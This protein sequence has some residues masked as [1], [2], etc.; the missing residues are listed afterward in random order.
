MI[1]MLLILMPS[2]AAGVILVELTGSDES[3]SIVPL[4]SVSEA[5]TSLGSTF[6]NTENTHHI[7]T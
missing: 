4:S 6:R 2:W 3:V 7:T 1:I 5:R